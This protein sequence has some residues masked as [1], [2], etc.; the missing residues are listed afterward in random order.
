MKITTKIILILAIIFIV[1]IAF[2]QRRSAVAPVVVEDSI[3]GC[4]LAT[5]AKDRYLLAV[6]AVDGQNVEGSLQYKNFEKDSSRGTFS[7]TYTDGILMGEY[8]FASEGMD[9][10][11]QVLFKK[12]DQGFVRGFGETKTEG[13]KVTLLDPSTVSYEN[14]PEFIYTNDCTIP[15]VL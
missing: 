11:M 5:I 3:K 12:T 9:S 15:A 4:Y 10:V 1:V 8:A 14:S 13:N 2:T 6:T 7:G